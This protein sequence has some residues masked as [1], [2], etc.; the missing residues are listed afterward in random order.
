MSVEKTTI[1]WATSRTVKEVTTTMTYRTHDEVAQRVRELREERDISQRKLA[2]AI[3]IDPASMNRI[4]SGQRGIS[5]GELIR[6]ADALGVDIDAILRVQEMSY[7]LRASC[8]DED[9]RES[10]GFFREV[11]ADYFAAE[12]LAR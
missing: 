1:S 11:I 7:A 5:T 8:P 9:V 3:D 4:E 6:I 12:A 2:Q 10:L